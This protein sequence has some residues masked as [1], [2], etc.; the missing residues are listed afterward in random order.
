MHGVH[1]MTKFIAAAAPRMGTLVCHAAEG[2]A[3]RAG[4]AC[5]G[6]LTRESAWSRRSC[7]SRCAASSSRSLLATCIGGG[8]WAQGT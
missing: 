2:L 6:A 5:T 1:S 8:C 7:T 4:E 3:G